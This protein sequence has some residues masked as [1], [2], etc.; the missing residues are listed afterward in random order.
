MVTGSRMAWNRL[1]DEVR[2]EVRR[3]VG[4]GETRGAVAAGVGV[5]TRTVFRIVAEAGGMPAPSSVNRSDLRLS[6]ADREEISRGLLAGLSLKA[7]AAGLGRHPTSIGR[8]VEL[9]GG[10][11]VYR[12]WRADRCAHQRAARPKTEKLLAIPQLAVTVEMMLTQGFSPEQIQGR[13]PLEFPDDQDMRVSHETIYRSLF[14]HG[15]GALRKELIACLRSGR[16][17]RRPQRRAV[18]GNNQINEMEMIADRPPEIDDRAIPGHWEGDLIL[19][20]VVSNSSIGTL[21]ERSSRLVM[22]FPLGHDRTAEHTRVCLTELIQTLPAQMRLSITWDQGREM[23]A[24]TQFSIDTGVK[25]Y[26]CDPHSPWQRG[27][28]ENTNGLLRQYFPKGT[29]LSHY[30]QATCN[31]VAAQL[32]N[33]PRKTLDYKTPLE[34][35][36][37]QLAMTA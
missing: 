31:A 9:D 8:E 20:S 22:L 19:G 32:N 2:L 7:I 4:R 1:S 10:R 11:H 33:R 36:N 5:S 18:T 34:S 3:R 37:E 26:F 12:A 29:D 30:T 23:A 15:R 13:L 28:N 17:K 35:Y 21:V 27:T 14:L 25:V 6:L 24:H 16:I